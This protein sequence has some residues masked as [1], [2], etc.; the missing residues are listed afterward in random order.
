VTN[1][2]WP[3]NSQ[4]SQNGQMR[5]YMSNAVKNGQ[6]FWNWP[7]YGQPCNPGLNHSFI[8]GCAFA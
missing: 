4:I 3:K 6:I 7:R 2:K 5:F 1:Q 8:P